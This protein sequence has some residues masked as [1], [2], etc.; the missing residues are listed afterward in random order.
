M[1]TRLLFGNNITSEDSLGQEIDFSIGL[2]Y[3]DKVRSKEFSSKDVC[4]YLIKRLD[5]DNANVKIKTIKLADLLAK[6]AGRLFLLEV[7]RREFVDKMAFILNNPNEK[8]I[9]LKDEI[10]KTLHGWSIAFKD[11]PELSY[12]VDF[13][14]KLKRQGKGYK[15]YTGPISNVIIQ[16]SQAPEWIDSNTCMRCRTPFTFSNRKH[17][18]RHC[19]KCYCNDC[20]NNF[21][22]IPKFGI[23][24]DVRCCHSCYLSLKNVT[25]PIPATFEP[26]VTQTPKEN[27]IVSQEEEDFKKAIELSL[28]DSNKASTPASLPPARIEHDDENDPDLLAAIEASLRDSGVKSQS[29]EPKISYS[30]DQPPFSNVKI[31]Q[32]GYPKDD[33]HNSYPEIPDTYTYFDQE[34]SSISPSKDDEPSDLVL[35]PSELEDLELF[36]SLLAQI[37]SQG[38]NIRDSQQ[39]Q[40]LYETVSDIKPRITDAINAIEEKHQTLIKLNDRIITAIKIYDQILDQ[41]LSKAKPFDQFNTNSPHQLYNP[42]FNDPDAN[43]DAYPIPPNDLQQPH[44]HNSSSAT[45]NFN[46]DYYNSTPVHHQPFANTNPAHNPHP[47]PNSNQIQNLAQTP[48]HAPNAI[49]YNG[50]LQSSNNLYSQP[51]PA[52]HNPYNRPQTQENSELNSNNQMYA[53]QISQVPYS[54]NPNDPNSANQIPP[55]NNPHINPQ[56]QYINQNLNPQIPNDRVPSI[57]PLNPTATNSNTSTQNKEE[58]VEGDLIQF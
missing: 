15:N 12:P 8:S 43:R 29:Y 13:Y 37:Q 30:S 55:I 53:K 19:G 11:D 24:E 18:C 35:S 9:E 22:P 10:T 23:Y 41:K 21:L 51:H 57:L 50:A 1:V 39:T 3:S 49:P 7:S 54:M 17:H 14:D 28:K 44:L 31:D 34:T 47:H 58:V 36:K 48:T 46:P 20:A 2:N 42:N 16:T 6:N 40:Y 45:Q 25:R 33:S 26:P 56:N 4:K 27:T 38:R 32:F 5:N 52:D